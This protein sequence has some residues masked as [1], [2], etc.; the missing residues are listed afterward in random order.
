YIAARAVWLLAQMGPEGLAK[1][2]PVLLFK[3]DIQRLG[4]YRALRRTNANVIQLA[5]DM[6]HDPSPAIRRAAALALRDVPFEKSGETLV[7]IAT[8]FDG[9]DRSY[10]EAFGTGCEGKERQMFAALLPKLG[11]PAEQWSDAFARLVWRLSPPAAVADL[12]TR[13]L[14]P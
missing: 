9:R 6:S 11:A 2:R 8:Q 3:D 5:R 10:L 13:A 7:Y 12:K 4:A 14:S 1:M